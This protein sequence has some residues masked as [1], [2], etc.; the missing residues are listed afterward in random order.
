[1]SF[2]QQRLWVL[3][4]TLPE[5]ATYNVPA[6]YRLQGPVDTARLQV[7]L[8]VIQQRHEVL[9][10]A[11]VQQD[12]TLL[13]EVLPS[14]NVTL[15]WQQVDWQQLT[16]SE[17]QQRLQEEVRRPFDLAQAPLWRAV[18]AT[19][20]TD[21]HILVVT[22]HHSVVDEWSLAACSSRN[23]LYFTLPVGMSRPPD[24]RHCP[25]STPT[26]P[27]GSAS[28]WAANG[29]RGTR[30]YW[31]EQLTALPPALELPTDRPRPAR[32]SGQG[33]AHRFQI[34]TDVV[35]R[36]RQLA[37][38]EG[39]SLFTLMLATYQVWLHRYTGQD[40]LIVGTPVAHRDRTELQSLLG[41]FLNTLPIRTQLDATQSFRDVLRVC[42][43]RCWQV[44]NT[45]TCRLNRWWNWPRRTERPASRRST[46]S[47]SCCWKKA[48]HPGG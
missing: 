47:C 39:T 45:A 44:W 36:V 4:Q 9:R 31:T 18:W 34:P 8:Q 19:L 3:Q 13:Q 48:L 15:P 17:W 38:E 1:M 14:E 27:P 26:M 6:V 22:F 43:R 21:D 40:D 32:P 30:A 20:D 25:S 12:E 42:G 16:S 46:R 2:G 5:A 35:A 11:L 23:S 10:T 28:D 7:C 33:G 29:S 41:F 24:C 37:H